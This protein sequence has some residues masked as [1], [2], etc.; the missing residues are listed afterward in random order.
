[1]SLQGSSINR[2]RSGQIP[3]SWPVSGSWEDFALGEVRCRG[4]TCARLVLQRTVPGQGFV[5]SDRVVVDSVVLGVLPETLH[6]A[7]EAAT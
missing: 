5:R 3:Q 4:V 1:M 2:Q 6:P 7:A